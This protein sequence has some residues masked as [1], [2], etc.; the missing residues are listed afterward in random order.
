[1]GSLYAPAHRALQEEFG[2]A[3][4]AERLDTDHVHEA[5]LP[6][7]K[8]FI[9]GRD[10]LFL[11]TV[12]PDGNPTVSYK[13]GAPGFVRVL[14]AHT[15]VF[16]GY[17]GNGMFYSM[18]NIAAQARVGLLF[19]DFETP[20]RLRVQGSARLEREG[21]LLSAY[22]EARYLVRVAVAKVWV[23]CPRYVHPYRKV[24]ESRYVPRADRET[25]LAV[26]KRLDMLQDV[27][28]EPDASRARAE[29]VIDVEDY[30]ARLL[31]G[32]A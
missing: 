14:D 8:A 9:E 17:D 11:S 29:G 5:I 1:M 27:L 23:N 22:P 16:P 26:W 25:P 24:A 30:T 6:E 15:L 12:D 21:A 19:I 4:L 18:G 28:A 3:R 31:R 20:H 2:T 32:E 10:M 13:G 7:E